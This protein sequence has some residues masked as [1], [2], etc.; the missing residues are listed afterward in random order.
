MIVLALHHF[1]RLGVWGVVGLARAI[2]SDRL[3]SADA[4]REISPCRVS[5]CGVGH[6]FVLSFLMWAEDRVWDA[7]SI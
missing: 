1:P 6:W 2:V 7:S 4:A 5:L 3:G